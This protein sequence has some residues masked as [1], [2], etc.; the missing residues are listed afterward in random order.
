MPHPS[1]PLIGLTLDFETGGGFSTMPW[2]AIRQNYCTVIE[3]AGGMPLPLP[4]RLSLAEA[5]ADL[6]DGLVMTGGSF[7]IDPRLYGVTDIHPTV[8]LKPGRTE[9][10]MALCRAMLARRK[11][12]LGICGGA[13]LINVALGGTLHQHV[14]DAYPQSSIAHEQPNPRTESGHTVHVVEGSLLHRIVGATEIAV[15]SAHHQSVAKVAP[16]TRINAQAADGVIEGTEYPDHP[17][18]L[19]VQWH[20]EYQVSPA[21]TAIVDAFLKACG[22]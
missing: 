7:D 16:G 22:R 8:T 2:Y 18:C 17:F 3:D 6:L 20:P 1:L 13:Q 5:Y 11:P 9:M 21:D 4:H 12:I 10:E 19:G 14:P 15:N